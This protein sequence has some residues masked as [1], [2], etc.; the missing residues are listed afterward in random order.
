MDVFT[1]D[2]CYFLHLKQSNDKRQV[3]SRAGLI[4]PKA[5]KETVFDLSMEEWQD[6]YKLLHEVKAYIDD[7]F[8]P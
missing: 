5:H 3:L 8:Y 2:D 1:N 6:T 4:V 7:E